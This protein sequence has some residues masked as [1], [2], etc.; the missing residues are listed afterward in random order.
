MF[1]F[2]LFPAGAGGGVSTGGN[3][4]GGRYLAEQDVTYSGEDVTYS[5]QHV[6][7][8]GGKI[9]IACV[10]GVSDFLQWTLNDKP[11]VLGTSG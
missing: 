2:P 5:G 1:F 7:M 4:A 3:S 11:I 10:L 6:V 8:E 9:S